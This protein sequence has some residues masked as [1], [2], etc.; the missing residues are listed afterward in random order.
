[1]NSLEAIAATCLM[2]GWRCVLAFTAA[3]LCVAMLRRP[4]RHLFG[5]GRACQLWLVPPVAMLASQ[6]PHVA[7]DVGANA[8]LPALVYLITSGAVAPSAH[9]NVA[10]AGGWAVFMVCVWAVGMLLV[11]A[12]AIAAQRRYREV[13]VDATA[14]AGMSA[15]TLLLRAARS[16]VG[17]ALVGAWR[18]RIVIPADF[19]TRYDPVERGL[20]LAHERMHARRRDGFWCLVAQV[21]LAALWFHPLAWWALR[22]LSHDQ[23]LACDAAVL[24]EHGGKRRA[25]ATAM[26][27]TQP[28]AHQL[29]VGCSWSSRHP[30]TERIAMLKHQPPSPLQSRLGLLGG[31]VLA[32][33]VSGVVYAASRPPG[34]A[35]M[36]SS[37][38]AANSEYQLGIMVASL[39]KGADAER[40]SAGLC[41]KSGEPGSVNNGKGWQL[42]ATV[43]PTNPGR[44]SVSL[45]L[46]T[47]AGKPVANRHLEGPLG[48][49]L[50][51][52]FD[53]TN[54]EHYYVIDVIPVAGCPARVDESGAAERLTM[55]TQAVTN[56]PV[57]TVV[58]S[59]ARSAGLD[60]T[61]PQDLTIRPVTLNF[62]QIPAGRALQL[63]ADIDGKQAVFQ[64]KHVRFDNK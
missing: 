48:G 6:W 16:D 59:M 20:I 28:S 32:T 1:M 44:V 34:P 33:L 3:V 5:A 36:P 31:V 37:S 18:S 41:M 8:P 10:D 9:G 49:P 50:L 26:L 42:Q 23:E 53:D 14:V 61:N 35:A 13:L 25:Y 54:G 17:P 12:R 15:S 30:I 24:Q 19:E 52:Q 64:G 27:K 2:H 47:G 21:N 46:S 51:A 55:I 60:I 7:T 58:E 4:F 43:L 29:P 38:A 62:E 11:A 22:A 39:S 40:T 57:R 56:Q 45:A 63:V